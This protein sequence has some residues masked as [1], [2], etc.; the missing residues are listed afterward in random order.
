MD[1]KSKKWLIVGGIGAA[2]LGVWYFFFN[3]PA[4]GASS[5]AAST[6]PAWGLASN[7]TQTA[8]IASWAAQTGQGSAWMNYLTTKATQQDINTLYTLITQYWGPGVAPPA[9]LT[10][11]F[12]DLSTYVL[13]S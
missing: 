1:K 3:T 5:T 13:G 4:S 9:N 8:E 7:A 12:M 11:Y 6:A 2:A 10:N